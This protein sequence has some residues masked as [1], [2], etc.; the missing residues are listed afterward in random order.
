M[1]NALVIARHS[2][3]EANAVIWV[4]GN[5]TAGDYSH[6]KVEVYM[7]DVLLLQQSCIILLSKLIALC[8]I[9]LSSLDSKLHY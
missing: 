6:N 5:H 2:D 9:L 4:L 3:P 8:S 7:V 1:I